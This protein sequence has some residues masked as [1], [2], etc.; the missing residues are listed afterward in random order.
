MTLVERNRQNKLGV[1]QLWLYGRMT[2]RPIDQES[3]QS[4][5]EKKRKREG[6]PLI[7]RQKQID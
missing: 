1:I 2:A 3:D 4:R 6:A 5:R 7:G